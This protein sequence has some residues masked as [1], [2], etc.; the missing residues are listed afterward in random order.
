MIGFDIGSGRVSK[1]LIENVVIEQLQI[2]DIGNVL[3][4]GTNKV[5]AHKDVIQYFVST[6]V[7]VRISNISI[8]KTNL[9]FVGRPQQG[10]PNFILF[11]FGKLMT[12]VK[13]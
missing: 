8:G 4:I 2:F 7:D 5:V 10:V 9:N 6:I 1:G 3:G 12:N 11:S 13:K